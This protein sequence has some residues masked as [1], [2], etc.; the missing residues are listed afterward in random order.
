[1]LVRTTPIPL[2][3]H[4]SESSGETQNMSVKRLQ[5]ITAPKGP[6]KQQAKARKT[7]SPAD[8]RDLSLR[9]PGFPLHRRLRCVSLDLLLHRRL[10]LI[11]CGSPLH[12]ETRNYRPTGFSLIFEET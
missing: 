2:H 8:M 1:M 9:L 12:L 6:A 10:T 5:A 7:H 3:R 4:A 11:S